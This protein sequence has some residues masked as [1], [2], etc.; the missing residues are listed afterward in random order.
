MFKH[1]LFAR[2]AAGLVFSIGLISVITAIF[3]MT[4]PSPPKV[5]K[6]TKSQG[7]CMEDFHSSRIPYERC[8]DEICFMFLHQ[9]PVRPPA[10]RH[11]DTYLA[12]LTPQSPFFSKYSNVP[13]NITK[14]L[15]E[16]RLFPCKNS[17]KLFSNNLTGITF[18]IFHNISHN[19]SLEDALCVFAGQECFVNDLV[20]FLNEEGRTYKFA[21][22]AM[23]LE[24]PERQTTSLYPSTSFI[25]DQLVIVGTKAQKGPMQILMRPFR[26]EAWGLLV[27]MM[28]AF[29][30]S[31]ALIVKV[32]S[33]DACSVVNMALHLLGHAPASDDGA[34]ARPSPDDPADSL[35]SMPEESLGA[36]AQYQ[37]RMPA[38]GGYAPA[39]PG[40]PN[41]SAD[42]GV[43]HADISQA[44]LPHWGGGP[45]TSAQALLQHAAS[46]AGFSQ[47][48]TEADTVVAYRSKYYQP[49][50]RL[51]QA[52][53]SIFLVVLLL[54]YEVAVVNFLFIEQSN[55][56]ESVRVTK[57]GPPQLK[58]FALLKN[59]AIERVW[60]ETGAY[61]SSASSLS[62]RVENAY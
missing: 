38:G 59:S 1:R 55:S 26:K 46:S 13:R 43:L 3:L 17:N 53:L 40:A 62:F 51:W 37:F 35:S 14:S 52:A 58:E 18:D 8:L 34:P 27:G 2:L 22:A 50:V 12:T 15:E 10:R 21:I 25:D 5:E 11:C 39:G 36:L 31:G 20:D 49:A 41:V 57:L 6:L 44:S 7:K 33:H 45:P 61:M 54:F 29:I 32:F 19:A 30:V 24:R 9:P 16:K 48:E 4:K 47:Q 60:A 28:A 56:E 23:L 42:S